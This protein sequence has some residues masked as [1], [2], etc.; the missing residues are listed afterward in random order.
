MNIT[1]YIKD[2]ERASELLSYIYNSKDRDIIEQATDEDINAVIKS[3][4]TLE[5]I[6][7]EMDTEE[8]R[9][10]SLLVLILYTMLILRIDY[11]T[12]FRISLPDEE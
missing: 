6:I 12:D 5:K 7:K 9:I 4:S 8:N 10:R 1:D 2:E 11:K 3:I